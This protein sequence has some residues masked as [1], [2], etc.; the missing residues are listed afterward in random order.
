MIRSLRNEGL[1]VLEGRGRILETARHITRVIGDAG[2]P[3][4]I[5]G[6]V[7]VVLHG[8]IR[9]TVDVDVLVSGA[10]KPFA[11]ALRSAGY[12]FD[13]NRREFVKETVPVHLV[14]GDE[15]RIPPAEFIKIDDIATV[16]LFDLLN[17]KL[18]SGLRDPLRAIDLADVIGLIR[19][20]D[21]TAADAKSIAKPLRPD[22]RKLAKAIARQGR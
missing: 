10:A 22:F 5:I 7:A 3:A 2:L 11:E 15:V 20:N 6:G 17:M 18:D 19:C 8:Y 14:T 21:L 9:T 1:L 4:A 13:R 16:G 12:A